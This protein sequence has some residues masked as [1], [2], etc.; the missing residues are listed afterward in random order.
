MADIGT[1]QASLGVD[2]G[3]LNRGVRQAE[4]AFRRY[5]QMGISTLN[6]VKRSVFSLQ[7]A[8][9]TL[10]AGLAIRKFIK[11]A[12]ELLLVEGRLNLVA[13]ST[14]NLIYLQKELYDI[15]NNARV[16][17]QGTADLY[18][19]IARTS[20][21]LGTSQKDLLQVTETISKA[22][23]VSGAS[24]IEANAAL[25]QLSQGLASGTLRGD[26]L[27]SVL[28]QT[29]RLAQ[30]MATG[31]GVGIGKLREL[32]MEGELTAEKVIKS[33]LSQ[34]DVIEQ[35]FSTMPTTVGQALTI[36]NNEIGRA[37]DRANEGTT[38]ISLFA[39]GI[40]KIANAIKT[41]TT[42]GLL[43]KIISGFKT[44]WD[45]FVYVPKEALQ[46][47]KDV[48][49]EL[50]KTKEK[51]E[52]IQ[53]IMQDQTSWSKF[54]SFLDEWGKNI[55]RV[56]SFMG[57]SV[58][59]IFLALIGDLIS[60]IKILAKEFVYLGA[61]IWDALTLDLEGVKKNWK[62]LVGGMN[63]Y[64]KEIEVNWK[65]MTSNI[66]DN[67]N[68]MVAGMTGESN[69]P[70][71]PG[72]PKS[73]PTPTPTSTPIP[74]STAFDPKLQARLQK[75]AEQALELSRLEGYQRELAQ[76]RQAYE[77]QIS[78]YEDAGVSIIDL[79]KTYE[80]ERLKIVTEMES[81]IQKE[82]EQ[83]LNNGLEA[84]MK[85]ANERKTLEEDLT[86]SI[87]QL[88]LKETDYQIWA[89]NKQTDAWMKKYEDDQKM[90]DLITEYH[91]EKM[92]EITDKSKEQADYMKEFQIQAY[93]NI[94]D[95]MADFLFDP[96]D[97]GLK[98][99]LESF[100]VM[101]RQMVAQVMANK[102]L[103]TIF[104]G[105]FSEG[106]SV[107]GLLGGLFGGGKAIGGSVSS[108]SIYHVGEREP[109]LLKSGG[110]QY[111]IPSENGFIDSKAN[112]E[113]ITN[114]EVPI[115]N[116]VDPKVARI[117]LASAEGQRDVLNIISDNAYY[118]KRALQ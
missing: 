117:Y 70:S 6:S 47:F 71:L 16:V 75:Q 105:T 39:T 35:E 83:Q 18:A 27:R 107:G 82:R 28:E 3:P 80:N 92:N 113:Q 62:N 118:V 61:I 116:I 14:E 51:I 8:F 99:M 44:L 17:Y 59:D 65:V 89:L 54:I 49:K 98:G 56:F 114:V 102:I 84:V 24:A 79:T 87:N 88:T 93:R 41:L 55:I 4:G 91:I 43:D 97:K 96:F 5:Q 53:K 1:L 32:G 22:L 2:L 34:K 115:T 7:G 45:L 95:A 20:R 40:I 38:A 72:M 73:S 58:L 101:I 12:D 112:Q 9:I 85:W 110:K 42:T 106:G 25:I 36:L 52:D 11:T 103:T 68:K 81:E 86:D 21:E 33:L 15:S 74:T 37:I 57:K 23:I 26:E 63:L 29:P 50:E 109:E 66:L 64:N 10:G 100:G 94:Q 67:W 19:R 60:S 46:Y 69:L 30:A 111:L 90:L 77:D 104:G 78:V 48:N 108:G 13:D 31:L 76:L